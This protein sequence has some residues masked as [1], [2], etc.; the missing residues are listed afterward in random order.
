MAGTLG[1]P[2]GR[3]NFLMTLPEDPAGTPDTGEVGLYATDISSD[4]AE[5]PPVEE[6]D[7]H[8]PDGFNAPV[9]TALVSQRSEMSFDWR[10]QYGLT[11]HERLKMAMGNPFRT[12]TMATLD[13]TLYAGDTR[14]FAQYRLPEIGSPRIL[15]RTLYR[16]I[17]SYANRATYGRV[18]DLSVNHSRG[19]ATGGSIGL[20]ANEWS[21]GVAMPGGTNEVQVLSIPTGN[22]AETVTV[23]DTDLGA[24]GDIS[25]ADT[26]TDAQLRTLLAGVAAIGAEANVAVVKAT[27][28][29]DE[30]FTITFQGA[31]AGQPID[32]LVA[33]APATVTTDT[34]GEE[35][36]FTFSDAPFIQRDHW[37]QYRA[38]DLADLRTIDM[39][40]AADPHLLLSAEA[41]SF[42][43]GGLNLP[44]YTENRSR[45]PSGHV[46]QTPAVSTSVL[47]RRH[48]NSESDAIFQTTADCVNDMFYHRQAARCDDHEVWIDVWVARSDVPGTPVAD[49]YLQREYPLGRHANLAAYNDATNPWGSC[50]VTV[51]DPA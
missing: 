13:G 4:G 9:A 23:P 31:L 30:E 46:A 27:V 44:H 3:Q 47:M 18:T 39:N 33:T 36:A 41:G 1:I 35:P 51:I 38:D 50:V 29:G 32:P 17:S 7:S 37:R 43:L 8:T 21:E 48:R 2:T 16:G 11:L 14:P 45:N 10:P 42:S 34:P 12:G 40:D 5:L 26:V 6:H 15:T 49:N 24:G 22:G 20:A 28:G 25:V 19:A